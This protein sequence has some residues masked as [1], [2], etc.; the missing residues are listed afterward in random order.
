MLQ[1]TARYA[2]AWNAAWHVDPS[3]VKR[4]YEEF[5][6]ACVV[7]GQ[8]V[9]N[10]ELTVGTDV[11]L[12]PPSEDTEATKAITGSPEAIALHLESF[13]EAGVGHLIVALEP[14]NS[15]SIQQFGQIVEL[16]RQH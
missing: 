4:R 13:A 7:V 6:K 14:Q 5:K 9:V 3:A 1:L 15:E 12:L 11:R 8:D 2:N 10:V 16:L